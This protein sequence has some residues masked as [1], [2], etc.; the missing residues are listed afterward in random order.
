MVMSGNQGG[1]RPGLWGRLAQGAALAAA[2]LCLMAGAGQEELRLATTLSSD[3][4]IR[5]FDTIV[6]HNEFDDNE[7][8]RLRKWSDPVR[9]YLD[10]RAGDPAVI[11]ETVGAHVA[12]LAEITGHDIA[13]TENLA[14]ANTTV[15]FER[16]SL[17]E[18]VKTDYFAPEFDIHTVMQTNLCIGQY[19]S[20]NRFEINTAVVVIPIDRVMS[21][22]RL[23]ACIIEEL[24]QVLGLP[25]DSDTV[26]PSVFNDHSSDIDLSAQDVLLIKLLYDPRL[27]LGMPRQEALAEARA[28][29]ADWGIKEL[30]IGAAD[31]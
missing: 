11:L 21:R 26:F 16:D 18:A 5:N 17:L 24:T 3:Q 7:D 28:I 22:G 23:K 30:T 12:H 31:H 8:S 6:F 15:V 9:I 1:S 29:L 25:N 20:N 14:E 27:T 13:L 4:I 10:I 19:R 2:A